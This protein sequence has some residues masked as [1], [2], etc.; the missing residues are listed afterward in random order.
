MGEHVISIVAKGKSIDVD[1]GLPLLVQRGQVDLRLGL[2]RL[3][4]S[5][6]PAVA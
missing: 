1:A 6:N 3:R 4:A 5:V 2:Q